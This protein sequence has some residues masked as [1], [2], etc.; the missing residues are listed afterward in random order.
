MNPSTIV[1]AGLKK[2]YG[3]IFAAGTILLAELL[4][5]TSFLPSLGTNLFQA[6][7]QRGFDMLMRAR[8]VRSY[9]NDIIMI[10]IDDYTDKLLGWP[11]PR[12]QYGAVMTLLSNAGAKAV[13]L[14]VLLPPK[15]DVD[16]LQNILLVEYLKQAQGT[17]QV[18]G[19]FIPSVTE[20]EYVSRRDVDS[21]AHFVIGRFGIP[22]PYLNHFPRAP[23]I[24][25]F[26]FLELAEVSTGIGH[27]N[28]I[29]DT[30]DGIIR[31]TPLYIEYAG[32]LYPSIGMALAMYVLKIDPKDIS[33][34]DTENGTIIRA[35]TREIHT[36]LWGEVR[37]NYIGKANQLPSVSFYDILAAAKQENEKFFE[38]F[39]NKVC[40]IGPTIRSVG[41][42]YSNPI[43]ESSAGFFTHA[44][45]YDMIA[46][47]RFLIP[48][49][50]W[51]QFF[52]LALITLAIGFVAHTW[53]MRAGVGI[54]LLVAVLYS[55]F[56]YSAFTYFD[57][58]FH[59]AEPLFAFSLCFVSTIAFRAATEGRQRKMITDL[60]G[61][62]VDSTIVDILI[63]DPQLVKLG[64]EK[65]EIS[66][67]FSDIKGFSTISEK[68]DDETLVK[69]LNV[70]MT[71]MTNVILKHQGTVDKFIGDAIMAF[72]G[73]PLKDENATFHA[74]VSALEMQYRLD[75]LQPKLYKIGNV[76]I[77]QR[78]GVN[79]GTCTVGNMGSEQRQSY[80]AIGDPV[81]L[82]SRLEG[83]N[84][85][86]GTYILISETTYQQVAKRVV[87]REVDRVQVVGKT[88]PTRIYE[89][90]NLADKP[91]T[92]KTKYFLEMYAEGLKSYQERRWDEGIAYMEHAMQKIPN[93][94]V[95]LLYIERMKL[96]QIS[97]PLPDWNGV[98][99]LHSK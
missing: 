43:E 52:I 10:K 75:K 1:K 8:G 29:P 98:F 65:R 88:E 97:P 56:A 62:Y 82:A 45:I 59:I 23:I 70:Y 35:G 44:N 71:D 3:F 68:V 22:A 40:I 94:P 61:R 57:V 51:I 47:N 16:T 15:K 37:I 32:R 78:I 81:N 80:T 30:L 21:S 84:K 90:I 34:E 58:L 86:Y 27:A 39:K 85:Q 17:F 99:V 5:N 11:I 24:N 19:P 77:R 53:K 33:F 7:E 63:N 83:A 69:L 46:T 73:A 55:I 13:A 31:S 42:Y 20:R 54:L 76:E 72:W 64:G 89:L 48:A 60:F 96:Y 12:D 28:L 67:L 41:D 4:F 91:I 36:G 6:I 14:D 93:D 26:P 50:A 9:G 74:C 66:I 79:T 2:Y 18:I 38:Q 92:D 87:A 95:C 25:D 49:H